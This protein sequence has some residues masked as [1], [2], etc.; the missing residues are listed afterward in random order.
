MHEASLAQSIVE[1]V[2]RYA[3]ANRAVEVKSVQ[4]E[5]GELTFYSREQVSFWIRIGFE[6][7]IAVKA[8]IV[9]H[10]IPGRLSCPHCGFEGKLRMREDPAYHI[11]VPGFSCPKCGFGNVSIVQGREAVV[12]S[13]RILTRTPGE[14]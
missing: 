14:G 7:T 4:I 9:F 1:T 6:K 5:L 8:K 10:S 13:I 11:A 3:E 2:L 12:K